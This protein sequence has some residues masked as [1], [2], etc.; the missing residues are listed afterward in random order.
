ME[1]WFEMGYADNL[2]LQKYFKT[3]VNAE[4]KKKKNAEH[5]LMAPNYIPLI[6]EYYSYIILI[7]IYYLTSRDGLS[8][9]FF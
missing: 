7:I 9:R 6:C 1:H 2:T 4:R 8:C 3:F 5:L